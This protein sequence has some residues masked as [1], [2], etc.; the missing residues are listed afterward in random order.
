MHL[1]AAEFSIYAASGGRTPSPSGLPH[2]ATT[3]ATPTASPNPPTPPSDHNG[4][5][6]MLQQHLLRTTCISNTASF[7]LSRHLRKMPGFRLQISKAHYSP[8][9]DPASPH[10]GASAWLLLGVGWLGPRL[11]RASLGFLRPTRTLGVVDH[12][13]KALEGDPKS[14]SIAKLTTVGFHFIAHRCIESSILGNLQVKA[15]SHSEA[16][17]ST[18]FTLS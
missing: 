1:F 14:S 6:R 7:P 16:V 10:A 17:G 11:S 8:I 13:R 15:T 3:Q 2:R 18:I 12:C 4:F 5:R 9:A